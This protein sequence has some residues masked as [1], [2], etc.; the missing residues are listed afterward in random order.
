[1]GQAGSDMSNVLEGKDKLENSL[2]RKEYFK[3]N[4]VAPLRPRAGGGRGS[5]GV[6]CDE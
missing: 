2:G 6:E 1:M 3:K 5:F 4:S